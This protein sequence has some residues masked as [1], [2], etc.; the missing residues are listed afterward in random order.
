[1]SRDAIEDDNSVIAILLDL[2]AEARSDGSYDHARDLIALV[3]QARAGDIR[4]ETSTII[5]SR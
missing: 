2:A 5:L 4:I 1:M 3:R